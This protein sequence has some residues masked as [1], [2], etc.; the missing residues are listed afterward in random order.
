[1]DNFGVVVQRKSERI[2]EK[3]EKWAL[4]SRSKYIQEKGR[5]T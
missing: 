2:K 1:M 3:R 5:E 4:G